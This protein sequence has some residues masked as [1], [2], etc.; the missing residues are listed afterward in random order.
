MRLSQVVNGDI[1]QERQIH[2][3][4]KG[5]EDRYKIVDLCQ[6]QPATVKLAVMFALEHEML[7]SLR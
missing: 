4:V 7:I 6:D 2:W 1:S 3:F 5:M